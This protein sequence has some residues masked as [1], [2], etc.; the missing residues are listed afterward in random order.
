MAASFKIQI[1]LEANQQNMN[2]EQEHYYNSP[3]LLW[4]TWGEL[5]GYITIS[6]KQKS[7]YQ[8]MNLPIP[9]KKSWNFIHSCSKC[10]GL[11]SFSAVISIAATYQLKLLQRDY[12][13]FTNIKQKFKTNYTQIS[14]EIEPLAS[15]N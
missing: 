9:Q 1:F 14:S 4:K 6:L 12:I 11:S 15:L 2:K 3:L 13:S 5:S 10:K 7:I 8:Y